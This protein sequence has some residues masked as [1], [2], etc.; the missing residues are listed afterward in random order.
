MHSI[1]C[2]VDTFLSVSGLFLE[3]D[4]VQFL[5][6]VAKDIDRVEGASGEKMMRKK[7][8]A[9][10]FMVLFLVATAIYLVYKNSEPIIHVPIPKD[11]IIVW[12]DKE[13]ERQVREQAGK[14]EG[15]VWLSDLWDIYSIKLEGEEIYSIRDLSVLL[16][17]NRLSLVDTSVTDL[18]PLAGLKVLFTLRIEGGDSR[19]LDSVGQLKYVLELSLED[20]QINSLDNLKGLT[21]MG[22]LC[23]YDMPVRDIGTVKYMKDLR[24]FLAH[25]TLID[26]ISPLKNLRELW[27]LEIF[28]S[29][30]SEIPNLRGAKNL[31]TIT[32]YNN[33][34]NRIVALPK[35]LHS[36]DMRYNNLKSDKN[37][38]T[39]KNLHILEL[40]YNEL[41]EI[42]EISSLEHLVQLS[43][44]YN[45]LKEMKPLNS[46]NGLWYLC[47]TVSELEN[48]D[49]LEGME[50]LFDLDLSGTDLSKLNMPMPNIESLNK[51]IARDCNLTNLEIF[52]GLEHLKRLD[53][54]ANYLQDLGAVAQLK[55]LSYLNISQ[56]VALGELVFPVHNNIDTVVAEECELKSLDVFLPISSLYTLDVSGNKIDSIEAIK[57]MTKLKELD[58]SDNLIQKEDVLRQFPYLSI[59]SWDW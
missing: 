32:L 26:D 20:L 18:S 48:Y 13:V 6:Q 23:L 4:N 24:K 12:S 8:Y 17:L 10:I 39:A 3:E 27:W 11:E 1:Y 36:L 2:K 19:I 53:V 54:R 31:T 22:V 51:V 43:L 38:K 45:N 21:Q 52:T 34:I 42:S 56:N 59:Q 49:F 55:E 33:K 50:K 25:D 28:N 47:L 16:N 57:D 9:V 7:R 44:S 29:E 58:I 41:E 5:N 30:V 40:D 37:I 15:D 46:S 35:N 14:S